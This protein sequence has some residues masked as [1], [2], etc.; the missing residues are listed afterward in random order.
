MCFHYYTLISKGKRGIFCLV[1]RNFVQAILSN[2]L[3]FKILLFC[4]TCRPL[5]YFSS[6]RPW[7]GWSKWKVDGWRDKYLIY[8]LNQ[9]RFDSNLDY[10]WLL[11]LSFSS[12][13]QIKLNGH[14][15]TPMYQRL[16]L[17]MATA[18]LVTSQSKENADLGHIR[19]VFRQLN[20]PNDQPHFVS[21]SDQIWPQENQRWTKFGYQETSRR[22][23]FRE[24]VWFHS[25][26]LCALLL[27]SV[28]TWAL[29]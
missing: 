11:W 4:L 25:S 21:P 15:L 1:D 3:G 12:V 9:T 5:V 26:Q 19:D 2:L 14:E 7:A 8:K 18:G 17:T 10:F 24:H 6:S 16:A 29:V 20:S 28:A 27:H 13:G 23:A 22:E